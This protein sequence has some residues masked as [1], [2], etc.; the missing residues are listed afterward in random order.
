MN[1][2]NSNDKPASNGKSDKA[3]KPVSSHRPILPN[4]TIGWWALGVS[5][6]GLASW[7]V[8]PVITTVFRA[9]YP[10]TD[11]WLMPAIGT[12][13]IDLAAIL[14][15]LVLWRWRERSLLNILA[16]VLVIPL[17]LIFTFMVVGAGLGGT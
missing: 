17:A 15:I 9:I 13:L 12:V 5:V 10:I 1:S 2:Q 3:T 14:N 16:A 8:F 4:T 11:T 7:V 6:V